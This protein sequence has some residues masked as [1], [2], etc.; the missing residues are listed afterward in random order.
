MFAECFPLSGCLFT[1]FSREMSFSSSSPRLCV[2]YS[3]RELSKTEIGATVYSGCNNI[4]GFDSLWVSSAVVWRWCCSNKV[5]QGKV[6]WCSQ[7]RS[8]VE[9][10]SVPFLYVD[11]YAWGS[12]F[13]YSYWSLMLVRE[14]IRSRPSYAIRRWEWVFRKAFSA[15][16]FAWK[17]TKTHN[18]NLLRFPVVFVSV[19]PKKEGLKMLFLSYSLC[20]VHLYINWS[21]TPECL[22][23]KDGVCL[24]T[25]NMGIR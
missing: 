23:I 14:P 5:F 24:E 4:D 17:A 22:H 1:C 11:R 25:I 16:W 15:A 18:W 12:N 10:A 3:G 19:P 7:F 21:C 2:R 8:R 13:N 9:I 20:I 6:E